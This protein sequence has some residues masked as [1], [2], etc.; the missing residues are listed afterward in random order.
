MPQNGFG[1]D[2]CSTLATVTLANRTQLYFDTSV[3]AQPP[4]LWRVVPLP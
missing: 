2:A 4:R 3:S 1:I